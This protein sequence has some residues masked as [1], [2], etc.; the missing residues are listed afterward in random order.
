MR[1]HI[2]QSWVTLEKYFSWGSQKITF[3]IKRAIWKL[4]LVNRIVVLH[5]RSSLA[6]ITYMWQILLKYSY[7]VLINVLNRDTYLL[8]FKMPKALDLFRQQINYFVN[9]PKCIIMPIIKIIIITGSRREDIDRQII[10]IYVSIALRR[11][12]YI[13]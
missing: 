5:P 3:E 1:C 9:E 4:I 11:V 8:L 7:T 13:V 2:E 10:L 12:P 6:C